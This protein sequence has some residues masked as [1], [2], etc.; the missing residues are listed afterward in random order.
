MLNVLEYLQ[1][2]AARLPDKTA[3]ADESRSFTFGQ[4]LAFAERCGTA[5]AHR[6]DAVSRP[7][8]VLSERTAVTAAAFQAVLASGNYY[9]PIDAAMPRQRMEGILDQLRPALLLCAPGQEELAKGLGERCP[10]LPLSEAEGENPDPDLLAVRREQVL[11]IDPVYAIFTSGSTGAPKGIIIAHRSV[12][13][14]VD[15]MADACGFT[16]ADVMMNQAPFYFDLS[17]KDLYLTLKCGATTYIPPKKFFLFPL[18]LLREIEEKRATALVWATSAF[19]LVA[20]SGALEKCRPASLN[21][22]ILGGEALLARDL[23]I[24]RS[25]LPDIQYTNLYGP[26]EVT[27]DCTWYPIPMD[28]DYADGE[29]IPIGRPCRNKQVLLLDENLAPVPDGTPGELCVRGI[30]LAQGYYGDW[31][32][33][34]AAFVQNPGNPDYPDRIYRTGDLGY[35]GEDGLLYFS[36]RRDNQIK[37]MGY[38]IELGEVETALS[39]LKGLEAAVC[40]YDQ[41]RKR[42]VCC[43]QGSMDSQEIAGAIR[44]FL[45]RY[46]QPNIYRRLDAMPYNAN[47]KIDRVKLKEMYAHEADRTV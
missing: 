22:V 31:D 2:S 18:L 19:H 36:A 17:V 23:N 1:C 14:F 40:F 24:W 47:G 46:M 33:T 38:R 9:V 30:G 26:T 25:A 10:V 15:W 8:A 39:R 29:P 5:I 7:I 45:P 35:R 13:D 16:E 34:K 32:K 21:K 12:I 4:L 11:D 28:K 3:F 42:I 6:V 41:E 44:D 37:H 27:V 20:A 43:Y